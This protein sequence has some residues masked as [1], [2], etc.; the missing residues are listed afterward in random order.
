MANSIIGPISSFDHNVQ[1]WGTFRSRLQ[2]WFIANGIDETTDKGG[3]K[4]RAILLSALN[5]STYRLASNLVLPKTLDAVEFQEVLKILNVHFT[6]K[7][8]GFAERH[9]FYS[10]LQQSGESHAQYAARLRGLAEHCSFKDL[11]EALRDKFVM[12][13][14]IGPEREK[15]FSMDIAELTLTKAVEL[16]ESVRCARTAAISTAPG[17]SGLAAAAAAVYKV[18]QRAPRNAAAAVPDA[19]KCLVCGRRSHKASE[20]RFAR[21]KC[22]KCNTK[23]HLRRMCKK[24]NYVTGEVSEGD[25]GELFS[26][27]C[28][29][30]APMVEKVSVNNVELNCEV[31]SGS[32]VTAISEKTYYSHFA[33]VPLVQSNKK[34]LSY[35]GGRIKSLGLVQLPVTYAGKTKNLDIYVIVEGGPPLLGRDFIS[36]FELELAPINFCNTEQIGDAELSQLLGRFPEVL[37]DRLGCF[38]KYKVKLNLKD[39]AKPIF[40]KARPV[41]FSLKEKI[42]KEID[43]LIAADVI[44]PIAHS[45]WASPIVPVLK[46]DGSVRLCAD[47]SQT[48]NKQLLIDKYPLPTVQELFANLHGGVQFTKLDMSSAYTQFQIT[49]VD[50]I[51]CIN[52][53][54]GLF[55]YKRL[56]FGLSSA[57]AIFQRALE[58]ILRIDGVLCF[59]DDILIT[60]KDRAEHMNRLAMVLQRFKE[61][62]LTLV[63]TSANFS[64]M[65]LLTSVTS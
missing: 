10:A 7:R 59:L 61:A 40:F 51:T 56:I 24:V 45:E 46:R 43:R 53:H 18:E 42:D 5:D 37:C 49:D 33:E 54:R 48:L 6:P 17:N 27:R 15:L 2:Q 44:E 55:K 38:N 20:C 58:S 30:G 47:Y 35:N 64:K 12:G 1:D 39:D 19:V 31:D 26:I 34:L 25:D 14:Q 11:E 50:N 32:S 41:A 16:A 57:P 3:V 60:G 29:D 8:C 21:Y 23:G 36:K 62:G 9:H 4:R 22:T 65:K 52:T 13:L 63:R 28:R